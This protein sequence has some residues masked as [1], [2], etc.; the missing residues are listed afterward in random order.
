MLSSE[1]RTGAIQARTVLPVPS[2]RRREMA[3]GP[4]ARRP[5]ASWPR[6]LAQQLPKGLT[7]VGDMIVVLAQSKTP[8]LVGGGD[9]GEGRVADSADAPDATG[10]LD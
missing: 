9:E 7:G 5:V 2:S 10:D 8:A 4:P 1:C 6:Q 3:D